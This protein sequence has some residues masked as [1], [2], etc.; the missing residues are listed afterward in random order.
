M[1]MNYIDTTMRKARYEILPDDGTFY[2][3]IPGFDGVYA[4]TNSLE[5]CR[6]ELREVLEEWI[7]FRISRNLSLPVV[8]GIELVITKVA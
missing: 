8:D 4:N 2:G 6:E 5:T 7:M 3:E 1:L